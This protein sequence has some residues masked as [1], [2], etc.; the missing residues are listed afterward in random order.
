LAA[1]YQICASAAAAHAESFEKSRGQYLAVWGGMPSVPRIGLACPVLSER[2]TFL[3]WLTGAG[4]EPVPMLDAD[5]IRRELE[6]DGFQALIADLELVVR[7]DASSFIRSLGRNRPLI[8][9]GDDDPK[10]EAEA[11]RRK[12]A[13]LSRPVNREVAMLSLSLA[14]AE[15]RPARRSPRR[16]VDR[17]PATIDGVKSRILD[18]SYDGIRLEVDEQHRNVLPPTFNVRVPMFGVTMLVQRVWVHAPHMT[19]AERAVWCGGALRKAP[20]AATEAWRT[21][22]DHAPSSM[23]VASEIETRN[24]F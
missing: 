13:Y 21:F 19:E 24:F 14:L 4:F 11:H 23:T 12:A 10:A 5:S 22:V 9:V 18:V 15:G 7:G 20:P 1:T 8:L 3:E 17:I 2:A 6:A 16:Q